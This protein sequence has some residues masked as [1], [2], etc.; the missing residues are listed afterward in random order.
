MKISNYIILNMFPKTMYIGILDR[1]IL[2]HK[3]NTEKKT[4]NLYLASI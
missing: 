3:C 4:Y 1:D 2:K